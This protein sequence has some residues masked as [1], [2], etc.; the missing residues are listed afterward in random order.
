[1]PIWAW[2]LIGVVLLAV[3]IPFKAKMTKK[4]LDSRKRKEEDET[5]RD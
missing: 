4:F 2:I 5:I 1:M 3:F